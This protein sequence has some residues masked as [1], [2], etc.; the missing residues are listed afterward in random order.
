MIHRNLLG[1]F[2]AFVAL[3]GMAI[4]TYKL[5]L[6]K[7]TQ[8]LAIEAPLELTFGDAPVSVF[9]MASSNLP[10]TLSVGSGACTID[11]EVLTI[12]GAGPCVIRAAQTGDNKFKAANKEHIVQVQK[13][14][15]EIAFSPLS[16]RSY[17]SA[18]FTVEGLTASSGLRPALS[19]SGSCA[20]SGTE[21]TPTAPGLCTLTASQGGDE[22]F[23]PASAAT[24]SFLLIQLTVNVT[25]RQ[26][27]YSVTGVT[28]DAIFDSIERNAPRLA[29]TVALGVARIE[30]NYTWKETFRDGKCAVESMTVNLTLTVTLPT[31][32]QIGSLSPS[33]RPKWDAFVNEI[34]SHEQRH[35]DIYIEGPREMTNAILAIPNDPSCAALDLQ[36]RRVWNEQLNL[37]EVRQE[38][39]HV[40]DRARTDERQR[41]VKMQID[42]A[43]A[44]IAGLSAQ[45]TSLDGQVSR[46][47]GE[48]TAIDSQLSSL[49]AEMQRIQASYP[50]GAP[51]SVID[52]YESLRSQYNS[53]AGRYNSLGTEANALIDQRNAIARQHDAL[54]DASQPLFDEFLWLQ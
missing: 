36:V 10:V 33:I 12:Q 6:E 16:P 24:Q 23:L 34:A 49:N 22:N 43:R 40:E 30:T 18:P 2:V 15:Q 25:Q 41:P 1:V 29:G 38:A 20:A 5:L 7:D 21:V 28:T 47:Q 19:A 37:V 32:L 9:G 45:I 48:R 35:V 27:T 13:A 11:Q 42:A 39:F 46:M 54:I 8:Q 53:L 3:A 4:G 31:H 26:N 52:R 50:N 51:S 14:S 17:P 44:R